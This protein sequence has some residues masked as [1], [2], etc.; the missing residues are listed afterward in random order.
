MKK[1]TII[2]ASAATLYSA[3][4]IYKFRTDEP[5][6]KTSERFLVGVL[7]TLGIGTLIYWSTIYKK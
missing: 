2:L 1:S 7:C 6:M 3:Y 5:D 4:K